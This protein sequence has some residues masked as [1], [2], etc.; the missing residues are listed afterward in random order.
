LPPRWSPLVSQALSEL[1]QERSTASFINAQNGQELLLFNPFREL[2]EDEVTQ[3][4]I[5]T[6]RHLLSNKRLNAIAN[7]LELLQVASRTNHLARMFSVLCDPVLR[8]ESDVQG[9]GVCQVCTLLESDPTAAVQATAAD[10]A[11]G[12]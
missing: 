2:L 8:T 1:C 10:L 7:G 11:A 5:R 12:K 3:A 6:L 9:V 4:P